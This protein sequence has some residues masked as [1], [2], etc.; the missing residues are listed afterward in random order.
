MVN[1]LI[2]NLVQVSKILTLH[3]TYIIK[4]IKE[5]F[6]LQFFLLDCFLKY[7]L[8]KNIFLFFLIY[9]LNQCIKIILKNIF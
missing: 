7:F 2:I 1:Y 8:F 6:T 4:Q 3:N 9:I 5:I